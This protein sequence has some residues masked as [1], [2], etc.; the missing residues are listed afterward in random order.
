LN[1]ELYGDSALK[2]GDCMLVIIL[3]N[4]LILFLSLISLTNLLRWQM[5][6]KPYSFQF[7]INFLNILDVVLDS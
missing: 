1:D 5:V 4:W 3:F 7:N 2:K 6:Q